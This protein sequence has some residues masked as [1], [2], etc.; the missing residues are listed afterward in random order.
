LNLFKDRLVV[1]ANSQDSAILEWVKGSGPREVLVLL[2]HGGCTLGRQQDGTYHASYK[3]SSAVGRNNS[4]VAVLI[5]RA[6]SALRNKRFFSGF[7]SVVVGSAVGWICAL[8]GV[9]RYLSKGHLKFDG[10]VRPARPLSLP[11]L[12]FRNERF[13]EPRSARLFSPPD[14]QPQ[15]VL[16]SLSGINYVLLR[17]YESVVRGE[18]ISDLDLLISDADLYRVRETLSQRLGL[19]PIDVYS[20]SGANGHSFKS[21]PYYSPPVARRLLSDAT[22]GAMDIRHLSGEPAYLAFAY[23]L[24]FHKSEAVLPG[25]EYLSRAG[26]PAKYTEELSRL[27]S[28]AGKRLPHTFDD[29]EADLGRAGMMPPLDTIGFYSERNSFL[30]ARYRRDS[31]NPGLSVFFGSKFRY[32]TGPGGRDSPDDSK[33]GI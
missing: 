12:V 15:K 17:W 22:P 23:H 3:S 1:V 13:G 2:R 28:D 30:V 19:F 21:A 24:L 10:I 20:E 4:R 18:S 27:A 25:T 9:L 11:Y 6:A 26:W 8:P 33:G 32:R 31:A 5:G 14:D 7:E 16:Q 29:L